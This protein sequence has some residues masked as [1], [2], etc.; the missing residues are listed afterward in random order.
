MLSWDIPEQLKTKRQQ[1]C[2]AIKRIGYKQVQ[3]SLWACPYAKADQVNLVIDEFGLTKYVA[4]LQVD[5]TD[6]ENHLKMMFNIK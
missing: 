1:F 3:K 5:R 6:I 4:Y 2:R